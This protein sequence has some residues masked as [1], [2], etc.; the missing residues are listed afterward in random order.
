MRGRFSPASYLQNSKAGA[1]MT[2][3]KAGMGDLKKHAMMF[4]LPTAVILTIITLGPLLYALYISFFDFR[5]SNPLGEHTFIGL[6]NYIDMFTSPDAFGAI[7]TTFIF[8]F[9]A[10]ACEAV[11]GF[12]LALAIDSLPKY[13]KIFTSLILISMMVAPLVVGLMYS[14]FLNPQFGLYYYLVS[15]FH[16][17]LPVSPLSDPTVALIVVALTDVWEWTP[18]LTVMFLAGLQLIPA[19]TF[20]AAKVDGASAWQN[21]RYITLPLMR[22][23]IVIGLI[24]RAMEAFK[25][26]DKPYILTGGGPGSAT[27]VIDMFAYRQAFVSF[28]FSYAAAICMV[29]FVILLTCGMLYGKFVMESSDN[30]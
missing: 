17:P 4:H 10:V 14:F 6:K 13:A 2:K 23:I 22:P 1:G 5:L 3:K 7:W 25:E 16:L 20:E 30:G 8:M 21:F 19:E 18:Y 9:I 29:L 24:L 12:S 28:N 15:T 11:L 27:E 26:F